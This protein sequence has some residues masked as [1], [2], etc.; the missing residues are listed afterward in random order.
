MGSGNETQEGSK[1]RQDADPNIPPTNA[2][3]NIPPTN[4]DPNIPPTNAD[5]PVLEDIIDEFYKKGYACI[6]YYDSACV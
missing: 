2:D 3:P 5:P 6:Y 1:R 4:A